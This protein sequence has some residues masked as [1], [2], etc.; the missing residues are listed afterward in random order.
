MSIVLKEPENSESLSTESLH[1]IPV[2]VNKDSAANVEKYFD[3]FIDKNP[4][5]DVFTNALRGHPVIG[6]KMELPKNWQGVVYQ[7]RKRPLSED[8]DRTFHKKGTFDS[9]TYWNYDK[10]PSRNDAF[11]QALQWLEISDVL[12]APENPLK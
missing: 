11:A 9:F 1:Y 4:E 12:H 3:Q 6:A 8:A 7:E 10:N 5:S 2:K